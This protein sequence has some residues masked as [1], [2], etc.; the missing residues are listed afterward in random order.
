[1]F[2][3]S[4]M[5]WP[6]KG[7]WALRVRKIALIAGVILCGIALADRFDQLPGTSSDDLAASSIPC[8]GN[9]STDWFVRSWIFLIRGPKY[10]IKFDKKKD[11]RKKR[12]LFIQELDLAYKKVEIWVLIKISQT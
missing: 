12:R 9:R 6:R 3:A 2:F 1:M 10:R 11:K 5:R 8:S 7:R 4:F